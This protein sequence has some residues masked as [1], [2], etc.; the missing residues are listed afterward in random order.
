M[1]R[2][3]GSEGGVSVGGAVEDEAVGAGGAYFEGDFG[4]FD[5]GEVVVDVAYGGVEGY[6][7]AVGGHGVAY[8]GFHVGVCGVGLVVGELADD[9]ASYVVEKAAEPQLVED[10]FDFIDWFRHVFKEEDCVGLENVVGGVDELGE[11]CKVSAQEC[12]CGYAEA[13]VFV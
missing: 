6:G 12:A 4:G 13:V 9:E 3:H 5:E 8:H 10:S 7:E 1:R 2:R 11:H